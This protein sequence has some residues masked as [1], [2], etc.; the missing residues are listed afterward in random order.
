M[1]LTKTR[2]EIRTLSN[3]TTDPIRAGEKMLEATESNTKLARKTQSV[4]LL[5]GLLVRK[6]GTNVVEKVAK[7]MS[8]EDERDE[9]LVEKLMRI[10]VWLAQQLK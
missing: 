2:I 4:N 1:S 9:A 10:M 7:M 6:V 3:Q 5:Q 8:E